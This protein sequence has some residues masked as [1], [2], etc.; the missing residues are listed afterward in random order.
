MLT[1]GATNQ[2]RTTHNVR[3]S[4]IHASTAPPFSLKLSSAA[5][6]TSLFRN[7]WEVFRHPCWRATMWPY[8]YRLCLPIS[9]RRRGCCGI[10]VSVLMLAQVVR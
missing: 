6:D 1:H 8:C 9:L 4:V 10:V 3:V 2:E 5:H 7:T